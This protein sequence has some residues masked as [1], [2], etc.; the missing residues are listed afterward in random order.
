MSEHGWKPSLHLP[1]YL[2]W[3]ARVHPKR[4]VGSVIVVVE[5]C[6]NGWPTPASREPCSYT[7]G[8]YCTR[9]PEH[10]GR[11]RCVCGSTH[12]LERR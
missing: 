9:E 5:T 6:L 10:A 8:C 3:A 4:R 11:C 1:A 12:T 7:G 2:P